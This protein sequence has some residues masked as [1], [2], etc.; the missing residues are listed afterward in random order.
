[1]PTDS[2]SYQAAQNTIDRRLAELNQMGY[3]DSEENLISAGIHLIPLLKEALVIIKTQLTCAARPQT[4]P[5]SGRHDA[6]NALSS[7][8]RWARMNC[9]STDSIAATSSSERLSRILPFARSSARAGN[10]G[11][12]SGCRQPWSFR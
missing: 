3:L 2:V 7:S 6:S 1:M 4:H 10:R 5:Q 8:V 12:H 9:S 11:D